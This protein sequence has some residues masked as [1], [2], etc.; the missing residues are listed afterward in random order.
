MKTHGKITSLYTLFIL[1]FSVTT[2]FA[3][4]TP[5][6][7]ISPSAQNAT[8]GRETVE[9]EIRLDVCPDGADVTVTYS[10][11]STDIGTITFIEDDCAR[12]VNVTIP[13]SPT[14][15]VD[16]TYEITITAASTAA[17]QDAPTL[18]NSTAII[19]I[20][21]P[22]SNT[23]TI[24]ISPDE[25]NILYESIYADYNLVPL[26]A[27]ITECPN[28]E[29]I[30]ATY[31]YL[32]ETNVIANI[33]I[34]FTKDDI[35]GDPTCV[36]TQE[37]TVPVPPGLGINDTFDVNITTVA[38]SG[39]QKIASVHPATSVITLLETLSD[40]NITKTASADIVVREGAF[41]YEIVVFNSG[42][43]DANVTRVIDQLPDDMN[44]TAIPTG[45]SWDCSAS[46]ISTGLVDCSYIGTIAGV[47]NTITVH[48]L[49]PDFTGPV[50]NTASVS[51]GN[52]G[53]TF[54]NTGSAEVL[55]VDASRPNGLCYY[56]SVPLTPQCLPNTPFY[57]GDK[58]ET[59]VTIGKVDFNANLTDVNITK[60][61]SP[62][63]GHGTSTYSYDD[64][65][66]I[67]PRNDFAVTDFLEYHGGYDYPTIPS[68]SDV[69]ITITDLSTYQSEDNQSVISFTSIIL[70]ATYIEDN[71][72]YA[73][74]L[75]PCP[76][77]TGSDSDLL[78]YAVEVDVVDVEVNLDLDPYVP[79]IKTK[80]SG[81]DGYV[82]KA[83]H[84]G[85]Y[86]V[87]NPLPQEYEGGNNDASITILFKIVDM[88]QVD[89][90]AGERCETA[91]GYQL[92]TTVAGETVQLT[93]YINPGETADVSEPFAM[94]YM[95]DGTN[96][97]SR[98]DLRF[99][100]K[101]IDFNQLIDDSGINCVKRS[102]DGVVAGIPSCMIAQDG[103]ASDNINTAIANYIAVFGSDA[104]N[105]CY[106]D[107]GE[108]C[109]ASNGGV[110]DYPYDT[111][112]GCF[113]CSIEAFPSVCSQD[114]F[115]I[116]PNTLELNAS[117]TDPDTVNHF[118][119][120]LRAGHAYKLTANALDFDGVTHSVGYN[121]TGGDFLED[122]DERRWFNTTPIT[123]DTTNL[124][125]G[126]ADVNTST[127]A[128]VTDGVMTGSIDYEYDDVGYIT[129]V[130]QDA[131]WSFVDINNSNDPTPRV[132]NGGDG[133]SADG[134][135]ICSDL[136]G[137]FIPHHFDV[138]AT[139]YNNNNA[140]AST[141]TYLSNDIN[142][143]ARYGVE[144]IPRNEDGG[145]T[146]N[147][148]EGAQYYEHNISVHIEAPLS[149]TGATATVYEIDP[150]ELIGFDATAEG[151]V[152][153]NDENDSLRLSFNYSRTTNTPI[154][155]FR[156]DANQTVVDVNASYTGTAPGSPADIV[157][158]DND[159]DGNVTFVY[160]RTHM[161]RYRAMCD[162][163]SLNNCTGAVTFFYEFY[164]DKDANRTLI[165]TLLGNAP[166]RSV[167]SVN[168]YRNT[169]HN[170]ST[171]GNISATTQTIPGT[172]TPLVFVAGDHTTQTTS[173]GYVYNGTQGY[174]YKATINIPNST[175]NGVPPWMVYDKYQADPAVNMSGALEFYGPGNWTSSGGD[176]LDTKSTSNTDANK[177]T[178]RRI[179]W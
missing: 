94:A 1:I 82:M 16:D 33:D 110:G 128:T 68:M 8:L 166:K 92:T 167:D 91:T 148:K 36:L 112:L 23:P 58:C 163:A 30:N 55:V 100:Y 50:T 9:L 78:Q 119:D 124:L 11:A 44:L 88:G 72:T 126:D 168:W 40:L 174:P 101:A 152:L 75:N 22:D 5:V 46:D 123:E 43:D 178:N 154:N 84:L 175:L 95:P 69:N 144:I 103:D 127:G 99:Q 18:G 135:Y 76:G 62:I 106:T 85:D 96:L 20:V 74:R 38:T 79:W 108:P 66:P 21:A 45:D 2:L 165:T 35:Y 177:N 179:R 161:P 160:G 150:A 32:D 138:E 73:G 155:P 105:S 141:F 4:N 89:A 25:K 176:S 142:M 77:G 117:S 31:T 134:A 71:I 41:S 151:N 145:K 90:A 157:G 86:D 171:D 164:S 12:I 149:G 59:S 139:L 37:F 170:T 54:N 3:S 136:N 162:A 114:N 158:E 14:L 93:T 122:G 153:W 19:T 64:G 133:C 131:N 113:E 63:V 52:D 121:Q 130:V 24:S 115:A 39:V 10:D 51:S 80:V 137:T 98:R 147:F 48:V 6:A 34:Y 116:R 53:N 97:T 172:T 7:S 13:L 132:E 57:F 173:K 143:S 28:K 27:V 104:Y 118:P 107:N 125:A 159:G 129:M 120:L 109:F 169:L 42:P 111:D 81:K 29:D 60:L 61:Y 65:G 146:W 49:A 26:Y 70:Y 47:G 156:I 83:V 17:N 56:D 67:T 15:V 140:G 87:D 102:A